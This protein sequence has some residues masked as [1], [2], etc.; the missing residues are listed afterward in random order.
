M[1]LAKQQNSIRS[2]A[3]SG[4]GE[5]DTLQVV[6]LLPFHL[7]TK[8]DDNGFLPRKAGRLREIALESLHGFEAAA[9][10]VA[11]AGVPINLVVVDEIPD[12]LGRTQL[13][14][15]ALAQ[16]DVVFGPLMR[17]N[18]A[19]VVP[20]VDRF[21]PEHVLLTDQPDRYVD[22]GDHVRQAVPSELAAVQ[23]LAEVVSSRHG[24]DNVLM[25]VTNGADSLLE[26]NF[27]ASFEASQRLQWKVPGDSLRFPAWPD[28]IQANSRSVGRLGSSVSPYQRNVVVSV[29]GRSA[30][31]MWAALQT[32]LQ[33]NDSADFV[34]FGH[35]ELADMPFVEGELMEKWRLTLPQALFVHWSD[36]LLWPSLEM[37]RDQMATDPQ[38]YATLAHDALVDA[39]KRNRHGV[40][41]T[42]SSWC[43]PFEWVQAGE[44]GPWVNESWT[45]TRFSDLT[46]ALSD[47]LSEVDPF[48]PRLFY[49]PQDRLI[50]V[51][52]EHQHLFP[53]QYP[54]N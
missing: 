27:L 14:S 23:A 40:S 26:A 53:S 24:A 21:R 18:V 35:P 29:A 46:W 54:Q 45:M 49:T 17:E 1:G 33:M 39:V 48:V 20:R 9:R 36:S 12:S 15:E 6:V 5:G 47:T 52:K 22:R 50:P 11:L 7:Q 13:S 19:D 8:V 42:L 51:P 41:T 28:T 10:E 16:A 38:K 4:A 34:V 2:L 37:Y 30:R 25:V 31:S 3:S 44:D 32:E 43:D